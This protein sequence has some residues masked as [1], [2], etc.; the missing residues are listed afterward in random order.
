LKI[1]E[2]LAM[3]N[4]KSLDQVAAYARKGMI[5]ERQRGEIGI[6]VIRAGDNVGDHTVLFGGIGER[7]E[8]T[9]RAS[10][11][12]TFATVALR[13]AEWVVRQPHGL[14]DMQ[15]VLGLR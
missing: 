10:S 3:A 4:G 6:Q 11:L 12:D 5:G 2:V 14:Y 8:V 7:L 15:D 13:G 1:A 9:H